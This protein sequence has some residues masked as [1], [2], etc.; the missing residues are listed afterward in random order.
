MRPKPRRNTGQ[1]EL[2]RARLDQ[3]K[4]EPRLGRHH[5]VGSVG[6][7]INAVLTA[8]DDNFRLLLKRPALLCVVL[9]ILL[10]STSGRPLQ[11]QPA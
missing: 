10:T 11:P 4:G 8:V 6:D 5:L 2:L 3:I 1:S 7:A 9:R